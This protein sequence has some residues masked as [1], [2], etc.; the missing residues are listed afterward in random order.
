MEVVPLSNTVLMLGSIIVH[1]A[2]RQRGVKGRIATWSTG[3]RKVHSAWSR[4]EVDLRNR[5]SLEVALSA[6]VD[7]ARNLD[8]LVYPKYIEELVEIAVVAG[9]GT[10][11]FFLSPWHGLALSAGYYVAGRNF[12]VGG[13]VASKLLATEKRIRDLALCPPG[14]LH[15]GPTRGLELPR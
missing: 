9:L 10:L 4:Q 3:V 1:G 12:G 6:A 2:L 15:I 7:Q 11:G 8:I 5:D 14:S 13:M